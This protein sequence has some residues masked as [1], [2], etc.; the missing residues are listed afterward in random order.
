MRRGV[1]SCFERG[2]L[3]LRGNRRLLLT[4]VLKSV[5][6]VLIAGVTLIPVL[7]LLGL[8]EAYLEMLAG[9][10]RLFS[11]VMAEWAVGFEL[12]PQ[13]PWVLLLLGLGGLIQIVVQTFFDAGALGILAAGDRQAPSQAPSDG[14]LTADWF[15]TFNWREFTGRGAQI[16]WRVLFWRLVVG[17]VLALISLLPFALLG[18]L[19][20]GT[21]G[22]ALLAGCFG[23]LVLL[24]LIS[25]AWIWWWVVEMHMSYL[26]LG[27]AFRAGS[28]SFLRRGGAWL[29][30][31][32]IGGLLL[33]AA[34]IP[35]LLLAS[36]IQLVGG[37]GIT[38]I[39]IAQLISSVLQGLIFGSVMLLIWGAAIA[40]ARDRPAATGTV[41]EP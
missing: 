3:N 10:P 22:V 8:A 29:L 19:V 33:I 38:A 23:S 24:T 15:E 12:P 35:V 16:I 30:L 31:T 34:L 2:A 27:A 26:R 18:M 1:I 28:R 39:V 14:A 40:L 32:G 4:V 5:L 7:R 41:V 9:R 11:E 13:M 37:N 17:F 6:S 20:E 36:S 25:L 21:R